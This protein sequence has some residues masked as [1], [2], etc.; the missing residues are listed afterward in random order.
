MLEKYLNILWLKKWASEEEIKKA[1]R[2]LSMQYHPDK[3][4]NEYLF[5]QINEAYDFFKRNWFNSNFE[6]NKEK[7]ENNYQNNNWTYKENSNE[8][9]YEFYHEVSISYRIFIKI[10]SDLFKY[11]EDKSIFYNWK[12]L[13][14]NTWEKLRIVLEDLRKKYK[15][16]EQKFFDFLIKF[17]FNKEL[18]LENYFSNS[19][20]KNSENIYIQ[21][22]DANFYNIKE[23]IKISLY[24]FEEKYH[25]SKN[26]YKF[27][28]FVSNIWFLY[29]FWFIWFQLL[30]FLYG[31]VNFISSSLLWVKG[32][33]WLNENFYDYLIFL[34][35]HFF[36]NDFW[37][38][39]FLNFLYLIIFKT[40]KVEK[41]IWT[42]KELSITWWI[43]LL[44]IFLFSL[45]I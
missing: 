10:I 1:Y 13:D 8:E 3:W 14:E 27:Y 44:I 24:L 6:E 37:F 39:I 43:F 34:I 25:K 17:S 21:W 35:K 7:N 33:L 12:T 30:Y 40:K 23:S 4:W 18:N 9:F 29:T 19:F 26:F 2:K 22:T 38:F 32:I 42:I 36:I 28:N 5:K 31:N 45:F 41:E 20:S 15:N 16:S 11:S